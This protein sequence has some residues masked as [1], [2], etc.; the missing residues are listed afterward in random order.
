MDFFAT[1]PVG[2]Q[3][4]VLV[5]SASLSN[6]FPFIDGI[7]SRLWPQLT[8]SKELHVPLLMSK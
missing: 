3:P 7:L 4:Q 6:S 1:Q 5:H 8:L 2:S